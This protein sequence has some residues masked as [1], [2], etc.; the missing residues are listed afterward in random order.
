MNPPPIQ[1]WP[2]VVVLSGAALRA[3][4]DAVLIAARSRRLSG[5]P[6]DRLHD[7]L[8]AAL[9]AASRTGQS[10]VPELAVLQLL[11]PTVS[12]QEAAKQMNL[13]RRQVRRLAPQLGGRIVGGRWFLDQAAID[14]HIE[15]RRCG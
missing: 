12:V 15:G 10:D 11:T 7:E 14:E 5:L 6:H 4:A 1:R 9:V 13:S 2:G 8:V 3:A